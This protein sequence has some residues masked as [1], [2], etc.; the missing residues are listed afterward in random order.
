MLPACYLAARSGR[1][2]QQQQQQQQR[3]QGG[4]REGK[5]V[6][7]VIDGGM[8]GRAL[9]LLL[10]NG[11]SCHERGSSAFRLM[12]LPKPCMLHQCSNATYNPHS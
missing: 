7:G 10:S 9:Q 5:G 12:V 1:Q 8:V 6:G 11:A 4:Q 2:Q 3:Q